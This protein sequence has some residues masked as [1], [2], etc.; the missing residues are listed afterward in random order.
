M[1]ALRAMERPKFGWGGYSRYLVKDVHGRI[2]STPD[3][4][5]VIALGDSGILG[6]VALLSLLLPIAVLLVKLRGSRWGDPALAGVGAAAIM[7]ILYSYDNLLNNMINPLFLLGLGGLSGL[8]A[9]TKPVSS[10]VVVA[11]E[12]FAGPTTLTALGIH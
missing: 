2:L 7:M 1:I 8:A 11:V 4:L 9:T 5:W 3:S 12:K 6:E 10:K